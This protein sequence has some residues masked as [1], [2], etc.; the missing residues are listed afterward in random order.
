[1]CLEFWSKVKDREMGPK[2]IWIKNDIWNS[3]GRFDFFFSVQQIFVSARHERGNVVV[4]NIHGLF[5]IYIQI[6]GQAIKNNHA[7]RSFISMKE[8]YRVLRK[9]IW[10]LRESILEE[11]DLKD[12]LGLN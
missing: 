12:D 6:R 1:M 2:D 10:F 9:C 7:N 3:W 11:E 5:T 4:L 8:N